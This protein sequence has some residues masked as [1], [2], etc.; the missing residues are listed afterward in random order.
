MSELDKRAS[1]E[2]ASTAQE[3]ELLRNV[4][5]RI[6]VDGSQDY[7]MLQYLQGIA[8]TLG[9]TLKRGPMIT[10]VVQNATV[11]LMPLIHGYPGMQIVVFD[12]LLSINA[13]TVIT[14][15]DAAGNNLLAPMYA[16]NAGQGYTMNSVRGK[17][18][19]WDRGLFVQST[20]AVAYGID[21]SY[22]RLER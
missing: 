1:K 6:A 13:A 21:I 18:L 7:N 4:H 5:H 8:A 19:P 20:N 15:T 17:H 9:A 22:C 10:A 14:L 3:Q 11:D 2:Q 16:P 12:I